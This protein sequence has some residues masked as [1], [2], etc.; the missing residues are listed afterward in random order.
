[1]PWRHHLYHRHWSEQAN[2]Y[3]KK[4]RAY[5]GEKEKYDPFCEL[6]LKKIPEIETAPT[7]EE[8]EEQKDLRKRK[9]NKE[10]LFTFASNV[11]RSMSLMWSTST[12]EIEAWSEEQVQQPNPK[13]K[14]NIKNQDVSIITN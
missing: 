11:T 13:D 2:K 7:L 8:R 5:E 10:R 9:A 14:E 6:Q 4:V 12:E 3:K 1:V